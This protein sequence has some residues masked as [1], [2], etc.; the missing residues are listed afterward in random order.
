MGTDKRDQWD[1]WPPRGPEFNTLG[2]VLFVIAAAIVGFY[3]RS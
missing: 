3:L 2:L 1:E